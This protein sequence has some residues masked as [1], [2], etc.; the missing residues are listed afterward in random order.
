MPHPVPRALVF[1]PNECFYCKEAITKCIY[2]SHMYGIMTCNS[3]QRVGHRDTR[4]WLH[5]QRC[6]RI[7]DARKFVEIGD[8]LLVL[9]KGFPVRRASGRIEQ[10][11]TLFQG[12]EKEPVMIRHLCGSWSIR[13]EKEDNY[14]YVQF[15]EFIKDDIICHL[16]TDPGDFKLAMSYAIGLLDEGI[17]LPQVNEQLRPETREFTVNGKSIHMI[18]IP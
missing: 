14:R 11:W 16:Q 3:H 10:G 13:C 4:A 12:F 17:Y 7:Q 18:M 5:T 2:V 8:V 9:D 6:V 1:M 15:D